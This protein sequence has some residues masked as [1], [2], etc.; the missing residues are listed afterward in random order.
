MMSERSSDALTR[1]LM[2]QKT[3][4]DAVSAAKVSKMK[5][6]RVRVIRAHPFLAVVEGGKR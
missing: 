5:P 6:G 1:Q 2:R 3:R 4:P